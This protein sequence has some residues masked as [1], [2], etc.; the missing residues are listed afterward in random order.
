MRLIDRATYLAEYRNRYPI[1]II[2]TGLAFVLLV[3]RLAQ[4]Q[5]F[6]G[7]A[8]YDL[9]TSNFVKTRRLE[10]ARGKILDR[11]G[12]VLAENEPAYAVYITPAFVREHESLVVRFSGLLGLDPREQERLRRILTRTRGLRRFKEYLVRTSIPW[13]RLALLAPRHLE[14]SGITFREVLRRHYPHGEL[15][16]HAIGYVGPMSE[17]EIR[18]HPE[19]D[20]DSI[21]GKQGVEFVFDNG[22][23]GVDGEAKLV[24]DARGREKDDDRIRKIFLENLEEKPAIPG[25]DIHLTLDVR[26][27]RRAAQLME[28]AKS[29]AV[30][31]MLAKTG[32]VL[33]HYSKP[34]FDPNLFVQGLNRETWERMTK[35][36]LTPMMDK[37]MQGGYFPGS[38]VKPFVAYGAL[39][40]G[41]VT[42][43]EAIRCG[44]GLQV[45]TRYFR[46][47]NQWGHG[48]ENLVN[49]MAHSCDSYFYEMGRRLGIDKLVEYLTLFGFGEPTGVILPHEHPGLVP[50]P[51][52]HY[53]KHRVHWFQGDTMGVSIGQ[54][55]MLITPLQ[56]AVSYAALTNGGTL[57]TPRLV[58]H[59]VSYDGSELRDSPGAIRRRSLELAKAHTTMIV[60]ALVAVLEKGGTGANAAVPHLR[61]A[62]K[63]GTAQL[64]QYWRDQKR[65]VNEVDFQHTDH[66]WFV[67]LSP[68]EDPEIVVALIME[69][70]GSGA[71]SAPVA[72]K[73]IQY[74]FHLLEEPA[75]GL[76]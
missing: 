38:V 24:A 41:K 6:Q 43:Q 22:L 50:T 37:V 65:I 44:G 10:P 58:G 4:I 59:V 31:A 5:L 47:W 23:R 20:P 30:V 1:M 74:Y 40:E 18:D 26:L 76:P 64:V 67:G 15:F 8:Y 69:H 33:V 36:A 2:L 12:E 29:G 68:P 60:R 56:L 62:G 52:W 14:L 57:W 61:I 39:N 32:E 45:G 27:Q 75:N 63:T 55:D 49:A 19:I 34:G 35:D 7:D 21:I 70:G 46:C 17:Q 11:N 53:R 42:A 54:G 73:L 72:T 16:A 25:D 71:R 28:P 51:Q 66:G 9:S 48:R 13:N 3:G